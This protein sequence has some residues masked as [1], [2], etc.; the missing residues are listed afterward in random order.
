MKILID[1]RKWRDSG[2][3]TYTRNLV[4][5]LAASDTLCHE[6]TL[7]VSDSS[8]LEITPKFQA[9]LFRRNFLSPFQAPGLNLICRRERVDLFHSTHFS[10]PVGLPCR[11][12]MTLHD[13]IPICFP[14][15]YTFW[16]MTYLRYSIRAAIKRADKVIAATKATLDDMCKRHEDL[17]TKAVVICEAASPEFR[18]SDSR[19]RKTSPYVLMFSSRKSHKNVPFM[20]RAWAS[21]ARKRTL[22]LR[23]AGDDGEAREAVARWAPDTLHLVEFLGSCNSEILVEAYQGA[24]ALLY[25]SR[26]EGFGLPILEAMACGTPV[27]TT[28]RGAM[29]EVAGDA[30]ILVSPDDES[31]LESALELLLDE[32]KARTEFSEKGLIRAKSFSWRKTAALTMDVYDEL[33]S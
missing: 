20:L 12:V 33:L 29:S 28:D 31:E 8:N 26:M 24:L 15:D 4:G 16:Q 14:Q 19:F 13:D 22:R 32:E 6:I 21:M 2:I 27:V 25:V 11:V 30:A 23:I 10:V 3:G 9:I 5:A 18:K 17:R 1:A 7:L